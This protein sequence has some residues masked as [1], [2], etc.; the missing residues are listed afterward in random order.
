M[1]IDDAAAFIEDIP[2]RYVARVLARMSAWTAAGILSR[3]NPVAAS[4]ALKGMHYQRAAAVLRLM[5]PAHR[6]PVLLEMPT[7]LQRDFHTSLAFPADT[8][9]A[10][11]TT[12]MLTQPGDHTVA[13]ARDQIRRARQVE[14]A[15][16]VVVDDAHRLVGVVP[17]LSLLRERGNVP[18]RDVMDTELTPL[19]ARARLSSV[20][21]LEAWDQFSGLP[22]VSRGQHVIGIL[23]RKTLREA[24]AMG[25]T[26]V[27]ASR[28]TL[29]LAL[30]ATLG[31]VIGGLVRLLVP[32][33][34]RR[35]ADAP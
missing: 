10:Y 4:A 8:V 18:L 32:T 17:L 11:M 12:M 19:S 15:G 29:P 28:D 20:V 21:A 35:Q 13:D 26:G 23:G 3:V 30:V 31:D 24:V 16:V 34:T 22:V 9:G 27:A 7:R 14:D 6:R 1:D 33:K 25:A 2:V 5:E